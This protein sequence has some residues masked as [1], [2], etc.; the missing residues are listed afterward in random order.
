MWFFRHMGAYGM[1]NCDRQASKRIAIYIYIPL[2]LTLFFI[3]NI[4]FNFAYFVFLIQSVIFLFSIRTIKLSYKKKRFLIFSLLFFLF[5]IAIFSSLFSNLPSKVLRASFIIFI[6]SFLIMFLTFSD[7]SPYE[8]FRYVLKVQM[9][10]GV[11]LS[12]VAIFIF[13]FGKVSMV[14]GKSVLVINLGSITF[15]QLIMGQPPIYRLSSLTSNPNTLGIILMFSQISTIYLYKIKNMKKNKFLFF[16]LIQIVTLLLT[17]SRG[18]ILTSILM[19]FLFYFVGSNTSIRKI[20][21]FIITFALST[22]GIYLIVMNKLS[23]LAR[24]MDGFNSRELA[25]NV[26]LNSIKENPFIGIGFGLSG[27]LV[28]YDL[29]IKAH[30]VYLNVLVEIGWIGFLFFCLLWILGVIYSFQ[31]VKNNRK[32]PLIK[33]TYTIIFVMLF[34]LMFHQMIENKLLVYDSVMFFW[35]YLITLS[36]LKFKLVNREEVYSIISE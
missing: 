4:N 18:A 15:Y 3:K 10:I 21:V 24:F 19:I 1:Q 32:N 11:F 23:I 36:T 2:L 22:T 31:G 26:I 7:N 29:G 35:I 25:W 17:Q 30:N 16:Y 20:K 14:A 13:L 27:E 12:L 9:Y 5:F 33:Y 34:S 6:P 28:T 8:T